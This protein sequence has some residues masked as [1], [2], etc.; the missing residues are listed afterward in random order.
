MRL[1]FPIIIID[2]YFRSDCNSGLGIRL[3]ASAIEH[4]GADVVRLTGLHDFAEHIQQTTRTSA[5]IVSLNDKQFADEHVEQTFSALRAFVQSIRSRDANV[6]IFLKTET[7]TSDHVPN[8]ILCELHGFLHKYEDTSEFMARYVVREAKNYMAQL[9]PPF[10]K[11]LTQHTKDSSYSWHCPGHSGGVAFLKTPV[12]HLFHEFFGENMLRADV[13]NAVDDLGQLLDHTGPVEASEQSAAKTFSADHLFFVT[14]GTSSSNKIVWHSV[15]SPGDV[16]VVDRNCHKSILHAIIMT[17]AIPVFI[18]PVRNCLGIIGPI[19]EALFD[20]QIIQGKIRN[21][22]LIKN[23]NAFPRVLVLTQCTYDGVL[24][25]VE[26]IKNKLDGYVHG[27]HF[28][29]AWSPHAAFHEFYEKYHAIGKGRV[30]CQDSMVFATQSTH[31]MLA[32]LS[33]ASQILVQNSVNK[34]LDTHQFNEAYLMHSSTSPHYPI[35]ASCDITAAMMGQPG[36]RALVDEALSEAVAFRNAMQ[37][38]K[39]ASEDWWFSIWQPETREPNTQAKTDDWLL[40]PNEMWHGFNTNS[41]AE[42]NML[43]P[44]RATLLTPGLNVHGEFSAWGIPA[45]VL[46]KYLAEHG[47]V[48]EKVSLYSLLIMF[49]I[50]ITKGRWNTLVTELKR[51][52]KL[53]DKNETVQQIMPKFS[54]EHPGY[55]RIGIRDLCQQIHHYYQRHNIGQ[56]IMA[57]YEQEPEPVLTPAEAYSQM[58]HGKT[59]RVPLQH[60]VGKTTA[61]LVTPYPPGIPLL[62]PGEKFTQTIVDYLL[63][64]QQ[65]NSVFPGFETSIH[66]LV[67]EKVNGETQYFIDCVV[68]LSQ[69]ESLSNRH[70]KVCSIEA[71]N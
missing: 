20:K 26:K 10:F 25:N 28:D 32:G 35:I 62:V 40:Q 5:F 47:I 53:F 29:E 27:L 36:G 15:V 22:P 60:L 54:Q 8:D 66:G 65:F 52:K 34:Q 13:C 11:A 31:K 6:P 12:G 18:K 64:A 43:D 44:T 45:A 3:L 1:Q 50:G 2:E 19:P 16:V 70:E 63:F 56:L 37:K 46:A 48:V 9:A 69:Y 24:Y 57:M 58:T 41:S 61:M 38:Y 59:T 21:H 14:N 4:A 68:H 49:T 67:S 30:R 33:Q 55:A 7:Q 39:R 42:F 71:V 17:G 23:K 51:F